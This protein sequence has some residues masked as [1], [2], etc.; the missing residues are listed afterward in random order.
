MDNWD[1]HAAL[2]RRHRT[3]TTTIT[4]INKQKQNKTQIEKIK[5]TNTI[6]SHTHIYRYTTQHI[7]TETMSKTDIKLLTY[8]FLCCLIF[9]CKI[10]LR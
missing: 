4:K 6:K 8:F 5:Q 9:S 7:Y 2:D 1:T 10:K 3:K